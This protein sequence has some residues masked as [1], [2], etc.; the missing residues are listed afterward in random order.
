[1]A[2]TKKKLSRTSLTK[3]RSSKKNKNSTS[4]VTVIQEL[5][6][7]NSRNDSI[8]FEAGDLVPT[9]GSLYVA[10]A[11]SLAL[12]TLSVIV[13]SAVCVKRKSRNQEPTSYCVAFA[14]KSL[15]FLSSSPLVLIIHRPQR[16]GSGLSMSMLDPRQTDPTKRLRSL[17]V[18]RDTL[19]LTRLVQEGIYGRIYQG[20]YGN[21]PVTIKSLNETASKRLVSS[22]LAEGSMFY[23][24][25]H[26]NVLTI[27]C[28]NLDDPKQPL[29]IYPYTNRGNLKKFLIKCRQKK[30]HIILSTQNLV[31]I[32]IQILLGIMYLHG[33]HICY[34]DIATRNVVIDDKLQVKITDNSLSRDLFPNDYFCL[35]NQESK[36]VK[37]MALESLLY[38]QYTA[39]SD[40]GAEFK[41]I[42]L[43]LLQ[44]SFGV[45]LWEL[46]TMAQ[47]PYPDV[48]P[49]ELG[50]FIRNGMRL[51]QPHGCPDQLFALMTYCWAHHPAER[52]HVNQMLAFLQE[53][54]TALCRFV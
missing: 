29:L 12:I 17:S 2:K 22:F 38:N 7:G 48:D 54:Y 11:C 16:P 40:V 30:G 27:L 14:L 53:F 45:L 35:Q 49:F 39:A 10:A 42:L 3:S 23:G 41:P 13:V 26:K 52:P 37:W 20:T 15:K 9:T 34:K 4:N 44:W 8:R 28:A 24:M 31:D 18:A 32:S 51:R 21:H 6:M 19:V 25:E 36:P 5:H 33:Q 1:M 50:V 46:T 47:Q 43:F